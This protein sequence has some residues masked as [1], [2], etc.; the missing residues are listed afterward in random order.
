MD[1]R[2]AYSLLPYTGASPRCYISLPS[3]RTSARES[4][5][6]CKGGTSRS[7]LRRNLCS[8]STTPPRWMIS[9]D[10]MGLQFDRYDGIVARACKQGSNSDGMGDHSGLRPQ[11]CVVLIEV[12]LGI[13]RVKSKAN[14]EQRQGPIP[15]DDTRHQRSCAKMIHD[16]ARCLRGEIPPDGCNIPGTRYLLIVRCSNG[17]RF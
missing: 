9:S 1:S 15:S 8:G 5:L 17:I 6:S 7:Q 10:V 12:A 11:R 3:R 13:F 14:E 16:S 2:L 4:V